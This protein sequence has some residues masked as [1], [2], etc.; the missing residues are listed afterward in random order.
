MQHLIHDFPR[1]TV[2]RNRW[3]ILSK[4][5]ATVVLGSL[6][7][8][9][10]NFLTSLNARNANDLDWENVRIVDWRI[11]EQ[12]EKN[13]LRNKN[14][15]MY[16]LSKEEKVP[17][18]VAVVIDIFRIST[19]IKMLSLTIMNMRNTNES[20]VLSVA[21]MG[22]SWRTVHTTTNTNQQKRQ[23][24]YGQTGMCC[25]DLEYDE[26]V[27]W[28]VHWLG[29]N[30]AHDKWQKH[31]GEL[32]SIPTTNKYLP[33]RQHSNTCSWHEE[34]WILPTVNSCIK[35]CLYQSWPRTYFQ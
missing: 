27:K 33:G 12:A 18:E 32:C 25:T 7:E 1:L 22:L 15:A 19:S 31:F 29:S 4:K 3:R 30:K 5:F 21:R 34:A 28:T 10:D 11:Y 16:F 26:L 8:S 14:Q 9:Y 6:P 20:S 17:T 13:I 2:K 23:F 35:C 24:K